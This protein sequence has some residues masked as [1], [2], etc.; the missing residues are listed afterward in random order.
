[1]HLSL[2]SV[3]FTWITSD[4]DSIAADTNSSPLILHFTKPMVDVISM[5]AIILCEA[6]RNLRG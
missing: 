1:M 6:L 4:F 5:G 3:L 2:T